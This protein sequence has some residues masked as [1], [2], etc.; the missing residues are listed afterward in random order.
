VT[1]ADNILLI[2][3]LT[4]LQGEMIHCRFVAMEIS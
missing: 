3:Y 1:V 4:T 2:A